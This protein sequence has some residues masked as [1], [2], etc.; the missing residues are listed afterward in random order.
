MGKRKDHHKQIIEATNFVQDMLVTQFHTAQKMPRS[1]RGVPD[2]NCQREGFNFWIEIKPRYANYRRDQMS[3][4][5]W[6]WFHDRY[7]QFAFNFHNRYAIVTDEV[8][9]DWF[10]YKNLSGVDPFVW[11]PEYHWA[12]YDKWRMGR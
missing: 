12:R 10:L 9:L 6:Q 2:L 5:Q 7:T 3:D 4:L 1:L 8:E 11:M